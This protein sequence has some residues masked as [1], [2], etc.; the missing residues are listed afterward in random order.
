MV[1]RD[2]TDGRQT[3]QPTFARQLNVSQSKW[4]KVLTVVE[5]RCIIE[6]IHSK[7]HHG[8]RRLNTE[9]NA[10][11]VVHNQHRAVHKQCGKGSSVCM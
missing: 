4:R 1:E 9:L 8:E 6:E 10:K 3:K 2:G 5:T 7:N 11:Y